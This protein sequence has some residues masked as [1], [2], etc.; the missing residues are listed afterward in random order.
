MGIYLEEDLTLRERHYQQTSSLS[1]NY[2]HFGRL[3]ERAELEQCTKG[4]RYPLST[5]NPNMKTNPANTQ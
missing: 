3:A 1:A 2:V 4:I 5:S